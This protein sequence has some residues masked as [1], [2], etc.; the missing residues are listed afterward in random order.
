M[1]RTATLILEEAEIV[2]CTYTNS[3]QNGTLVVI[4][5][6]VNDNGGTATAANFSVF[7]KDG[8][9]TDVTTGSPQAGSAT[10]TSSTLPP[11]GYARR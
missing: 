10:G 8:T 4:K 2:T 11:G 9:N 1:T 7:V 3:I 5:N 6:V